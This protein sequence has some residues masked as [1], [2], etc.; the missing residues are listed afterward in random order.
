[1]G[2]RASSSSADRRSRPSRGSCC[3]R[4]CRSSCVAV[5]FFFGPRRLKRRRSSVRPGRSCSRTRWHRSARTRASGFARRPARAD[6]LWVRGKRR[7]RARRRS[8]CTSTVR[9]RTRRSSRRSSMP[10][11]TSISSTNIYEPAR[12][13]RSC[14]I[15]LTACAKRGVEVRLLIDWVGSPRPCGEASSL[16]SSPPRRA[17]VVQSGR[18]P[19]AINWRFTNFRS[20]RKIWRRRRAGRV[21]RRDEHRRTVTAATTW[22]A[23]RTSERG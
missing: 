19:P 17:R 22:S 6:D 9:P 23:R 16:R 12:S 10:S 15:R 13:A 14:A 2:R 1:M 7:A 8:S 20:H 3:S 5:Y 4:G 11:T 18:E 21:H